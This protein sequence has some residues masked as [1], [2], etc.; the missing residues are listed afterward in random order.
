MSGTRAKNGWLYVTL[1]CKKVPSLPDDEMTCFVP[2]SWLPACRIR[3]EFAGIATVEDLS[4]AQG[5]L[6]PFLLSP[7]ACMIAADVATGQI[8]RDKANLWQ[9]V[10]TPNKGVVALRCWIPRYHVARSIP[11]F[12]SRMALE[13]SLWM[14]ENAHVYEPLTEEERDYVSSLA[15]AGHRR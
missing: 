4:K 11:E 8:F 13:D 15:Q 7:T 3:D 12:L 1:A 2:T 5:K 10:F 6:G 9:W 14:K